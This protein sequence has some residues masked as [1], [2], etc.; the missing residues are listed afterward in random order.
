MNLTIETITAAV[1]GDP[2][3][4]YDVLSYFD[5]YINHLCAHNIIY[6]TGWREWAIDSQ[7]KTA[8]QGKL[9]KALPKFSLQR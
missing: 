9:L 6:D 7:M 5:S 1:N 8:L 4:A 3:A 2:V